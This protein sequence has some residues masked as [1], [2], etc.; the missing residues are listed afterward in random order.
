[1]NIEEKNTSKK[2]LQ[3]YLYTNYGKFFISTC[4]RKSSADR[5]PFGWY[6]ETFAWKLKEDGHRENRIIADNSGSPYVHVA[7]EQHFEVCRQLELNGEYKEI[8]N[9]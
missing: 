1:M 7:F 6:Y 4:Y 8:V 3:S 5:D 2:F 9:E